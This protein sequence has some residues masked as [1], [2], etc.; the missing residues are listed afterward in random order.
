VY[1]NKKDVSFYIKN[2]IKTSLQR[3]ENRTRLMKN[4]EPV[5]HRKINILIARCRIEKIV[6]YKK[7]RYSFFIKRLQKI[8]R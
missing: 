7:A 3:G 4:N 8:I 5:A 6:R 1:D 2:I